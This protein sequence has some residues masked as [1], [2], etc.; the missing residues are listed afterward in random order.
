METVQWINNCK[1]CNDGV[2]NTIA[3]YTSDGMTV[4]AA[5]RKMSEECGGE[6][7]AKQIR[8]RWK[9]KVKDQKGGGR[10]PPKITDAEILERAALIRS[11]EGIWT[12]LTN[13]IQQCAC[14]ECINDP[15]DCEAM[16]GLI[17]KT[18]LELSDEVRESILENIRHYS[19]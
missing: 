6:F 15:N 13:V 16:K 10:K 17:S 2:C 18:F 14:P 9:Y 19:N 8:G 5:A 1:L 12:R 3:E 4:R 7:T 11:G